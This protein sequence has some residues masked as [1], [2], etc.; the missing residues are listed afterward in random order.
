MGFKKLLNF[1]KKNELFKTKASFFKIILCFILLFSFIIIIKTTKKKIGVV[2]LFHDNNAGNILV[3]FSMYIKLKEFGFDPIIVALS[4]KNINF[5]KKHLKLKMIKT[6]FFE[7][8]E[9][10]YDILMVNSDQTW[11]LFD[12]E[13]KTLNVGYLK[14]AENWTIPRFVYGASLGV[15]FWRFSRKFDIIARRL[16]KKFSGI[17]VR[18]KGA[19][20]I[21]KKHLGIHP[22][23]VLDPTLIID[24]NYYL[25]LIKNFKI[26]FN[27]KKKYLCI[28]QLDR[29]ILLEKLVRDVSHSFNYK[30]YRINLFKEKFIEDFIYCIKNSNAVITDSFHGTIFSI[31]FKKPFITYINKYR[32]NGRFI[33]LIKI[34]NLGQRIVDKNNFT[35][36]NINLLKTP[37]NINQTLLNYLKNKSINFLKKNLNIK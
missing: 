3:K 11:N 28:Y 7:L 33:S 23:L 27:I 34:F 37:L 12:N 30:V 22:E 2:G 19:I 25:D 36:V 16:L 18:E 6:N 29:N 35:K 31:I 9:K 10:D 4:P 24:K 8:S 14:F 15:N 32:G 20:K 13:D 21:V 5:L 1:M 17:S 26:N